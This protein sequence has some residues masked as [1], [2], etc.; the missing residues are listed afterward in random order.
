MH[1]ACSPSQSDCLQL[2][3]WLLKN[4]TAAVSCLLWLPVKKKQALKQPYITTRGIIC[5]LA[6]GTNA[7]RCVSSSTAWQDGP[8]PQVE[9]SFGA[10]CY[11]AI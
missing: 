6:D 5:R 8:K 2:Q 7:E 11:P 1:A 4:I 10:A 3:C 9:V